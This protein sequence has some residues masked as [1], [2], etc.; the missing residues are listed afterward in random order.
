MIRCKLQGNG[1]RK[2]FAEQDERTLG[3]ERG[4]HAAF[5]VAVIARQLGRIANHFRSYVRPECFDEW[6][7]KAPSPV[8]PREKDEGK[9]SL[10]C[11]YFGHNHPNIPPT[12]MP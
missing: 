2:G 5:Q 12:T 7:E 11:L 3:R 10:G 4:L 8:H 6:R 9:R 1:P